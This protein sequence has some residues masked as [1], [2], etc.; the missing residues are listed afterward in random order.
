M[1][2]ILVSA[3]SL[4][5]GFLLALTC[6]EYPMAHS[7]SDGRGGGA[8][9]LENGDVNGDGMFDITD[10]V[11]MLSALFTGG[12]APV[13]IECPEPPAPSAK[14]LRATGQTKCYDSV[15]TEVACGDPTCPGQDGSTTIGCPNEGR[16]VD[17]GD[18]TVTDNCTGL[19]WQKDTANL[20]GDDAV[21]VLDFAQWCVALTYCE[22]LTLA[23][24]DDWRL[25]NVVELESLLD[26]GRSTPS[27]DPVFGAFPGGY[28][29]STS[30]NLVPLS[31]WVVAFLDGGVTPTNKGSS[32]YVRAVRSAP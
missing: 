13:K 9:P 11:Y 16:F 7:A 30:F 20:D 10:P 19:M 1:K 21:T 23:G 24:H 15:G 27:I 26:Y 2:C 25:P 8:A 14:G 31:A 3:G 18:G 29:S 32:A 22:N 28:F 6:V 17:H 12:P 4:V 5:V